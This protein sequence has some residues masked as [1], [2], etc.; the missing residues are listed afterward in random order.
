MNKKLKRRKEDAVNNEQRQI[1]RDLRSRG[2]TYLQIADNLGLSMNTVKSFCRRYDISKKLCKN[3]GK[4]LVSTAKAKP[5]TFCSD[6]CRGVWWKN[7]RNQMHQK[8][9]YQFTCINCHRSFDSYGNRKRK[10]CSR[11]CYISHRYG[12]P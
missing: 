2:Q 12:V 5:K 8:A 9:I 1:I 11:S 6:R 10:F 3:C 4:P 7:N